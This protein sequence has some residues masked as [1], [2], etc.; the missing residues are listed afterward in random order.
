MSPDAATL[1]RQVFARDGGICQY[2][3]CGIDCGELAL[4][5]HAARSRVTAEHKQRLTEWQGMTAACIASAQLERAQLRAIDARLKA[6]GFCP[7][8]P[9]AEADHVVPLSEGGPNTLANLRV[10]CRRCH[11]FATRELAGRRARRPM[12]AWHPPRVDRRGRPVP[13]DLTPHTA[14]PRRARVAGGTR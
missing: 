4:S 5:Y 12:K 8:H 3:G 10:L 14:K 6:L 2:P 13:Q 7:D 9:F 1:R 11:C